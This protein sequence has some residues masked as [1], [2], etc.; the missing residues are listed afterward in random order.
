MKVKDL[1]DRLNENHK[2]DEQI[3]VAYW[4]KE[5]VESYAEVTL[6]D[7]QWTDIVAENEAH[8]PIGFE[9]VS[10]NLQES[11]SEVGQSIYDEPEND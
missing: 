8:E 2:P 3:I 1:I 9:R 6:T 4:D 11:A 7:D 5:T 10:D